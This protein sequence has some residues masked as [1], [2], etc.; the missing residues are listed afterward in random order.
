VKDF[1]AGGMAEGQF[2]EV[3]ATLGDLSGNVLIA[4]SVELEPGLDADE[5]EHVEIEG[6]ITD[7]VSNG[8]FKVNGVTVD[9]SALNLTGLANDVEIEVEGTMNADG[10]LVAGKGELEDENEGPDDNSGH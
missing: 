10:V 1:P 4:E 6:F 9:A 8:N 3:K 2:V 5:N 7:Y